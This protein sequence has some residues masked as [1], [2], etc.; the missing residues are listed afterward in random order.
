MTILCVGCSW[1]TG[2]GVKENETYPA[3]LQDYINHPVINAGY[4]GTSIQHSIW[5]AY[6]LIK[7]YNV[8]IVILQLSTFDR[9]TGCLDGRINFNYGEYYS[10]NEQYIYDSDDEQT[11]YKR[12]YNANAP[13][14]YKLLTLGEYLQHKEGEK[15]IDKAMEFIYENI[16]YSDYNICLTYSY[17]DML[18]SY[19][20][21]NDCKLIVFP[22][23]ESVPY[24]ETLLTNTTPILQHFGD[25]YILP[26]DK[27]YHFNS[28]GLR[29]VATEYVYPLIREYL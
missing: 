23:L 15:T 14:E 16:N 21:S 10:G 22:W 19:C 29:L 25:T 18:Y 6:R 4:P 9:W 26:K 17:I 20:A 11:K 28:N 1:T 8:K 27:G 2:L 24:I 5:T 12:V 7:E 13:F 3:H